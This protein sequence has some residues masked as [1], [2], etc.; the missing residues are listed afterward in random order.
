MSWYYSL[1]LKPYVTRNLNIFKIALE[2]AHLEDVEG[3]IFCIENVIIRDFFVVAPILWNNFLDLK[4]TKKRESA[5][6]LQKPNALDHKHKVLIESNMIFKCHHMHDNIT[7]TYI[8]ICV[9]M[10][11]PLPFPCERGSRLKDKRFPISLLPFW[12]GCLIWIL[13]CLYPYEMALQ[14]C[15]KIKKWHPGMLFS[16]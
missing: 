4:V 9:M 3:E 1:F 8:I 12:A 13:S 16:L 15:W 6:K 5:N 10:P 14:N 2:S 11:L 7:I